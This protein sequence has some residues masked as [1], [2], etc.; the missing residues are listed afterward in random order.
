[1]SGF[2]GFDIK[3][4]SAIIYNTGEGSWSTTTLPSIGLAVKNS[5][6]H[7][8][9]TANRYIFTASFTL[10]QNQVLRAL[11]KITE[12]K[13]DVNY[14]DAE[15]QKAIGMEKMSK[16]DFSG[17]MMLIRYVNSV[18]GY[19]GNFALYKATDNKLLSLP[20]E[21]LEDVLRKIVEGI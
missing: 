9:K 4:H 19:G 7:P 5:L 1:M 16:G 20:E 8:D 17:A 12:T 15:A 14:V 2:M 13:F 21:E 6:L 11:E 10:T 18:D 3:S